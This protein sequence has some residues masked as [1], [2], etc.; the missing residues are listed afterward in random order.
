MALGSTQP[1]TEMNTRNLPGGKGRPALKADTLT[2]ICKQIFR[3]YGRLDVSQPYWPPRPVI[4]IALHFTGR[5]KLLSFEYS[6]QH[7]VLK[8]R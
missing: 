3:I 5:F 4:G 7:P 2:A 6:S 1:L 8:L